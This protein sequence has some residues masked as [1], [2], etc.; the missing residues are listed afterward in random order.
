MIIDK[1]NSG[2]VQVTQ[3]GNV[4]TLFPNNDTDSGGLS[5]EQ[6]IVKLKNGRASGSLVLYVVTFN[7]V[8]SDSGL[9]AYQY[10]LSVGN[11]SSDVK[12]AYFTDGNKKYLAMRINY[13]VKS[14]KYNN[15]QLEFEK[16]S[17]STG[18]VRDLHIF[19]P[20]DFDSSNPIIFA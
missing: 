18:T 10:T 2:E 8:T 13:N 12:L 5:V 19:L 4:E 3:P 11:T 16:Y 14:I 20:D 1:N 6:K 15:E 7:A 9:G 17:S